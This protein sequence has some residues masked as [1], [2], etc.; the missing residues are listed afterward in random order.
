MWKNSVYSQQQLWSS[1]SVD[2]NMLTVLQNYFYIIS[3]VDKNVKVKDIQNVIFVR[4]YCSP[5]SSVN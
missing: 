1:L 2:I 5:P 4:V 3:T